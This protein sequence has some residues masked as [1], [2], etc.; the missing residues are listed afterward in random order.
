MGLMF[1]WWP[2]LPIALPAGIIADITLHKKRGINFRLK[3][4]LLFAF[5][6]TMLNC[7]NFWP[8]LFLKHSSMMQRMM[9]GDPGLAAILD[10]FT[11]K[12][13]MVQSAAAFMSALIG[14]S[15]AIKLI[16]RNFAIAD[17]LP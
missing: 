10:L 13:F 15:F 4:L 11:L 8:Y 14:G 16:S 7:A 17:E 6:V 5:Y 1:G 12:F 3:V 2:M 9:I